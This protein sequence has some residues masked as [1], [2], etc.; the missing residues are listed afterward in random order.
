[1]HLFTGWKIK[2]YNK[3]LKA[4]QANRVHNQP[5][6]AVLKKE[7]TLYYELAALYSKLK[8][9]KK[10]PY[11]SIM[12]VECYRNAA[13]LDDAEAHYRLANLFVEEGKF[14]FKLNQEGIFRSQANLNA[15]N[16]LFS[17]T[18]MH[19][20]AAEKLNHVLAKRLH[21]LCLINGWGVESNKDAGFDLIVDS[22]EQEGSW[23][24]VP[25]IFAEM[26]LNK[27]ELFVSI[28]QRR[29]GG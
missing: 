15:C 10:Y 29:K 6:D 16:T 19:L 1:M 27:P 12:E 2:S 20:E 7:I 8:G 9:H 3:K 11:A 4:M 22:I 24:R 13:D 14:R 5:A 17:Q 25:Q 28:M 18:L 23:D 21:G 26:G